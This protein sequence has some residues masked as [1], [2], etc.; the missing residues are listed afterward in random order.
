MGAN[1]QVGG[2]VVLDLFEAWDASPRLRQ[3]AVAQQERLQLLLLLVVLGERLAVLVVA[4]RVGA[5]ELELPISPVLLQMAS[6]TLR[7]LWRHG[8][9]LDAG[10]VWTQ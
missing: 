3:Q 9:R 8:K 5:P 7:H 2:Q 6:C 10:R 4:V 1:L